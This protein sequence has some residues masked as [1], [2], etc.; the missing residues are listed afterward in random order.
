M[1]PWLPQHGYGDFADELRLSDLQIRTIAGWVAQGAPRGEGE[2]YSAPASTSPLGKP[3]LTIQAE[4]AFTVP[5]SG[6]DV[7]WNFVFRPSIAKTRYVRA[8]E[9]DPANRSVVHHANLLIDRMAST[10]ARRF[11]RHGS[12]DHAQPRSIPTGIS[13]FGSRAA[14]RTLSPMASPGASTPVTS[15]S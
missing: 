3:D 14:R 11:R 8:V 12:C 5:A 6:P 4:R 15:L 10:P 9:I 13:F 7:Y 2:A 1:P